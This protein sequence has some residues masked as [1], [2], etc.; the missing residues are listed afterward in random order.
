MDKTKSPGFMYERPYFTYH[1]HKDFE[2]SVMNITD[3]KTTDTMQGAQRY[4]P[5]AQQQS[6]L[7]AAACNTMRVW[8]PWL[9]ASIGAF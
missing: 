6:N 2:F 3:I 8:L 1:V 5:S 7:L 9:V 4:D